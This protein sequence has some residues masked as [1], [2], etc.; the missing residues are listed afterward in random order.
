[1]KRSFAAFL[2]FTL[3][4]GGAAAFEST[5]SLNALAEEEYVYTETAGETHTHSYTSEIT[6]PS[7]C[8]SAGSITY[9]C[10][11]GD[12]YSEALPLKEHNYVSKTVAPTYTSQGYTQYTC[13]ECGDS[14]TD[15]FTPKLTRTALS[16]A[17]VSAVPDKTYTG[18]ALR[19]APAVTVS[20]KALKLGTD[21]TLS[22]SNNIKVGTATV[23]VT[24]K[25][26]YSGS[27]SKTFKIKAASLSKATV[28]AIANKAYTS[29]AIKPS[30]SVTLGGKRLVKGTDYTLTYKNNKAVGTATVTVKGKGNYTGSIKKT[31]KITKASVAK[32]KVTGIGKRYKYTG[33]AIKPA[34]KT[35]TLGSVTLKKGRDYTVSYKSNKKVGTATVTITGKGSYKGTVKKTFKILSAQDYKLW[36]YTKDVVTLVNKERTSRGLKELK[37]NETLYNKAMIRSKELVKLFSH[38]RPNGTSCFTVLEGI[39]YRCMG[40]NIAAGQRTPKEVVTDWMNSPGH[41]ANILSPDF[42][43]IGV[44]LVYNSNSV[45]GYFWTQIF[46]G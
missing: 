38:T 30:P 35:V 2:A 26:A 44:G 14:Y 45:Y 5:L 1:M 7:T 23:T 36:K 43:K 10:E 4:L 3:A 24:G 19:P 29:K 22:Y 46:L 34:V 8:V 25:G 9:Y 15:N 21:Y 40:E 6:A 16:A 28:A 12:S 32:A 41:R 39:S 13:S 11:C 20:G 42:T 17:N 33:K 31:F 37:L 27:V 18:S